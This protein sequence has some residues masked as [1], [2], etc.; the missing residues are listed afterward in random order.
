MFYNF[1]DVIIVWLNRRQLAFHICVCSQSAA[2]SHSLRKFPQGELKQRKQIA[3]QYFHENY[4]DL[5]TS[6]RGLRAPPMSAQPCFENCCPRFGTEMTQYL[7]YHLIVERHKWLFTC[8]AVHAM[9][10]ITRGNGR[11]WRGI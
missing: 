8:S 9:L 4:F 6:R 1:A 11:T 3:V 5:V 2:V 7:P 10:E